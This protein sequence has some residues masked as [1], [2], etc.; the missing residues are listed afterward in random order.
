MKHRA[1]PVLLLV[2]AQLACARPL[3]E[4]PPTETRAPASAV[5]ACRERPRGTVDSALHDV[6]EV[7]ALTRAQRVAIASMVPGLVARAIW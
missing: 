4:Q 2:V 5:P 1:V 6:A 7:F 3:D